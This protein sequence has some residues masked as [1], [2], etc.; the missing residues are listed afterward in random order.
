[1][2]GRAA[3]GA[4]AVPASV[5]IRARARL[6][7]GRGPPAAAPAAEQLTAIVT[8][9][10]PDGLTVQPAP[11]ARQRHDTRGIQRVAGG[12]LPPARVACMCLGHGR[13]SPCC[14]YTFVGPHGA[15]YGPPY[16]TS[17][18]SRRGGHAAEISQPAQLACLVQMKTRRRCFVRPAKEIEG[19]P[20][21][22]R[23][24]FVRIATDASDEA[25][26]VVRSRRKSSRASARHRPSR[27]RPPPRTRAPR[28]P[29]PCTRWRR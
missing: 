18:G 27:R 29:P 20:A 2:A 11:S 15:P 22:V 9:S 1:M 19:G 5:G 3:A 24:G 23:W 25:R 17:A 14:H 4:A 10:A 12:S 13:G 28:A 6:V 16:A 26:A 21:N 7:V 8:R